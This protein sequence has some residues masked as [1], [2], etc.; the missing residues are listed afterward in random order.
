MDMALVVEYFKKNL[1]LSFA[2][3]AQ[4]QKVA[5]LTALLA[6]SFIGL[7]GAELT[8]ATTTVQHYWPTA[9]VISFLTLVF[10]ATPIRMWS[11]EKARADDA[12]ARLK[13]KLR[14]DFAMTDGGCVRPNT[15]VTM[16]VLGYLDGQPTGRIAQ[17]GGTYYR[18]AVHVDGVGE[19]QR[20]TGYITHILRNGKKWVEGENLLL[21]FAPA[22]ASDATSKNLRA[23]IVNYLDFFFIGDDHKTL[24]ITTKNFQGPS[25]I[26][27]H[28]MF[29]TPADYT[30]HIVV[31][32]QDSPAVHKNVPFHWTGNRETSL[33]GANGTTP[34]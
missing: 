32:A 14:L 10:V 16:P 28:D 22:E 8:T 1:S 25:S 17:I 30:L 31:T 4:G 27:W 26:N 34:R 18:L 21:T 23:G 19:I 24:F 5:T 33:F 9:L 12:D 6:A 29:A 15:K 20:C 2:S 13:P 3:W 7:I 11:I